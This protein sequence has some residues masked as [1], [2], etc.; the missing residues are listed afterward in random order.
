MHVCVLFYVQWAPGN[1][2]PTVRLN[3]DKQV[4]EC[5]TSVFETETERQE[6][7]AFGNIFLI[8]CRAPEMCVIPRKH[9]VPSKTQP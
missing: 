9:P 5:F 7:K 2:S 6:L 3:I 1:G 8:S 4:R